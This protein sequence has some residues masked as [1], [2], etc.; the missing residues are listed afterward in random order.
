M[1]SRIGSSVLPQVKLVDMAPE[2]K[3][4]NMIFSDELKRKINERLEKKEQTIL[5]LNRRGF[6]TI[7]TCQNCGY[8][9]ECPDC[10][11]ALTYHKTSNL[12]RCHY[13]GYNLV[14]SNICSNCHEESLKDYGLGTEKLEMEINKQFPNARTVRMDADT[15]RRKGMHKKIITEFSN[16][17]YDILLGTQMIAKGLDFPKVSLVGVINADMSLNIPD[18]RSNEKTFE[19]LNQVSGRAGRD[20]YPGEVILQTFNTDNK[21][22]NYVKDNNYEDFYNYEMN[23]RKL[24]S[25]PPY[26]YLI[27]IKVASKEYDKASI[28]SNKVVK[29]LKSALNPQ[30]IILGPTTAAMFRINNVYRFQIIIKYKI[31]ESIYP[32]LRKLDDLYKT[33]NKVAIEIDTSPNQI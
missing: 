20:K 12:M 24:M 5:L 3:K 17:E 23:L 16:D 2:M 15:T 8:T 26:Y 4:R 13:C 33:N 19:L 27:S 1:T 7:I 6:S 9:Y 29:F 10:G 21:T 22:L 32:T 31:D 25:Y 28:E 30:T 11:I 14:K 18:F